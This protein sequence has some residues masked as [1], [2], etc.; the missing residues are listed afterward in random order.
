M[1]G[2][3]HPHVGGDCDWDM[4]IDLAIRGYRFAY[5]DNTCYYYLYRPGS[6]TRNKT[7]K[8][9]DEHRLEMRRHF[10]RLTLPG[11]EFS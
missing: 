11:P 2:G 7:P 5:T 10:R 8:I 1:A 9:W 6:N 3:F 4:W